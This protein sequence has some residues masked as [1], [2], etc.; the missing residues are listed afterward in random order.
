MELGL[1][2]PDLGRS[3]QPAAVE[4][5]RAGEVAEAL[6]RKAE[7]DERPRAPVKVAARL[8][9]RQALLEERER[10]A[11]C[12]PHSGQV[13]EVVQRE[14][15]QPGSSPPRP[16]ANDSSYSAQGL[17]AIP[18]TVRAD[19]KRVDP[20]RI[21]QLLFRRCLR[22]LEQ[23]RRQLFA[24]VDVALPHRQECAAPE[25]VDEPFRLEVGSERDAEVR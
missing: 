21:T 11:R 23:S 15:E 16:S 1:D 13:A 7:V 8:T 5:A 3:R 2:Q 22:D 19:R 17:V 12:R 25:R 4:V 9:D 18:P 10:R 20:H 14:R 24:F 6:A